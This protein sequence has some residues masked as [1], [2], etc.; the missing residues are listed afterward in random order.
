MSL[1]NLKRFCACLVLLA[2]FLTSC[3]GVSSSAEKGNI[4]IDGQSD[5]LTLD[6]NAEESLV[7]RDK[8]GKDGFSH[9]D[10]RTAELYLQKFVT[11]RYSDIWNSPST[12]SVDADLINF[13]FQSLF[14][15]KNNVVANAQMLLVFRFIEQE[16]INAREANKYGKN[17]KTMIIV[18]EAH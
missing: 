12:L 1:L 17:L 14:A 3:G 7:A 16:I 4:T 18:D 5:G 15:N 9:R 10:Y 2:V 13:S 8:N 6:V 11:G